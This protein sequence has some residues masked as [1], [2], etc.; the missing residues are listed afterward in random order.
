MAARGS[1]VKNKTA[2]SLAGARR[3]AYKLSADEAT[4]E[5]GRVLA[6]LRSEAGLFRRPPGNLSAQ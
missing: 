2:S 5:C 1:L 6:S 4:Q 3:F